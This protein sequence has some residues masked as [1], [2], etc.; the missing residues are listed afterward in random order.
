VGHAL[1]AFLDAHGHRL[2]PGYERHDLKHVLLGYSTSPPDEMR[3]Q[4]FMTG[5]AGF[6]RESLMALCFLPWTPDAWPSLPRHYVAG[7][8]AARAGG[9][10]VAATA[11]ESLAD[12]QRQLGLDEAFR[13]A[14]AVLA[15]QWWARLLP[16]PHQ[17]RHIASPPP[18]KPWS[19]PLRAW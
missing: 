9:R 16:G 18:P 7:R 14:D 19:G 1:V 15:E 12:L 8:Y 2:V 4:A 3:M 17:N 13:R 6:G 5:N 10:D 11:P